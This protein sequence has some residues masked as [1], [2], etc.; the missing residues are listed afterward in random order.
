MY[1]TKVSTLGESRKY[2]NF[3]GSNVFFGKFTPL[4]LSFYKELIF[5]KSNLRRQSFFFIKELCLGF[6]YE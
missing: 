5:M 3:M 6:S 2:Q 4:F 1:L